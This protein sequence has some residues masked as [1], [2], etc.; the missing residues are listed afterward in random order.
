MGLLTATP[1]FMKMNLFKIKEG[2]LDQWKQ[3]CIELAT[4]KKEE[5]LE[6]LKEEKILI[7]GFKLFCIGTD[8]YTIGYAFFNESIQKANGEKEINIIHKKNKTECLE[9]IMKLDDL[10]SFS[11]L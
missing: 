5:A 10:Y 2:K 3:W 11:L 8:Y 1:F 9:F 7:E 6:T 4:T